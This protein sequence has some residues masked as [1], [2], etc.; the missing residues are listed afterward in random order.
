MY[1]HTLDAD[2]GS[3]GIEVFVFQIAEVTSVNGIS[4]VAG[5]FFYVKVVSTHSDFFV[6]VE[7]DT[8]ISV[9]DFI[10]VSEIAHSLYDFSNS[11]F[12]VCTKK[13]CA[14]SYDDVLAFVNF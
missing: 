2:L 14:I 13:G 7:A 10:M 4:P 8:Y 6:R 1:T 9:L 3:C 5:K 12:I 11:C